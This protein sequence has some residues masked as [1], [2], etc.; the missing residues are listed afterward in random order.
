MAVCS[1]RPRGGATKLGTAALKTILIADDHDYLRLLVSKTLGGPDYRILEA[2]DGDETWRLCQNE[3][4]DLLILDWMMPGR[5]GI[6]V[7]EALRADPATA[8]LR[9]IM[10]TART[11]A[12][13]RAK[14]EAIGVTGYLEK[15]F[16]PLALLEMVEKAFG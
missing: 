14:A 15:P 6:E 8:D 7:V 5:S 4:I 1:R 10:L 16:S 9:V 12:S 13:D 3:S 2:A 11:Q